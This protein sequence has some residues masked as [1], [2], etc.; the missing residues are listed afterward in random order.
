MRG[1]IEEDLGPFIS[2]ALS[3]VLALI[4]GTMTYIFID[5]LMNMMAAQQPALI[6]LQLA[7]ASAAVSAAPQ[8]AVYCFRIFPF[9]RMG[10][11]WLKPADD[12][13]STVLLS[14]A[15][16][17]LEE[18]YEL[19]R[20]HI[21]PMPIPYLIQDY[22]I[23]YKEEE[24]IIGMIKDYEDVARTTQNFSIYLFDDMTSCGALI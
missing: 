11:F 4:I 24:Q 2:I 15:P 3:I 18:V 12:S 19:Q 8:K 23:L 6:A 13:K 22:L 21:G 20:I 10:T 5:L 16:T 14:V 17:S 1:D 9:E 7:G